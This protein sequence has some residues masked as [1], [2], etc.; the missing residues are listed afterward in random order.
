MEAKTFLY[1]IPGILVF[2]LLIRRGFFGKH[3]EHNSY[4][5]EKN[6]WTIMT[7]FRESKILSKY[8]GELR[9]GP[10][11]IHLK[12]EPENV[13]EKQFFGDWFYRTENGVYLQKWNSNPI[14][15]GVHTEANNDL[16][17]Y[18]GLKNSIEIIETGIDSFLWEME[19]N[20]ENGLT[21]IYNK[22][23]TENRIKITN[24]L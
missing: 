20:N 15:S 5:D 21:L 2:I 24:A 10:A 22:G 18:D 8:A 4:A 12:T 19:K 7:S 6:E 11:F 16:I 17:Y 23:E 9:F 3:S 1:I 13:F 14:K